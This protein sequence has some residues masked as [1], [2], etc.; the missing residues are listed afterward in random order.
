MTVS[1]VKP[2]HKTRQRQL[3][4]AVPTIEGRRGRLP[5][6]E[7]I[8]LLPKEQAPCLGLFTTLAL[9]FNFQFKNLVMP[10]TFDHG[11]SR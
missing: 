10:I 4:M 1:K 2:N 8:T 5:T 11:Q 9:F 3:S 7:S 6:W